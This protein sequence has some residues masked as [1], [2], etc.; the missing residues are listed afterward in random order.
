MDTAS[1][2]NSDSGLAGS[3]YEFISKED[4]AP[5]NQL[6][7]A[8]S[9]SQD[10]S[11][12]AFDESVSESV[13]SLDQSRQDDVHSIASTDHLDEDE[14][15]AYPH[16]YED[17]HDDAS[18]APDDDGSRL[19]DLTAVNQ[20][21]SGKPPLLT[22]EE[23]D[24]SEAESQSSIEY[25]RQSLGT[26]SI[27][28]PEGSKILSLPLLSSLD[29]IDQPTSLARAEDQM[30]WSTLSEIKSKC[31]DAFATYVPPLP[32]TED[33]KATARYR[34]E[35][36]LAWGLRH[37]I[38]TFLENPKQ[39]SLGLAVLILSNLLLMYQP[40]VNTYHPLAPP[41]AMPQS[42]TST[43]A[44]TTPTLEAK[45]AANT[46]TGIALVPLY[47]S[48]LQP[49]FFSAKKPSISF[50]S[51]GYSDL[52]AYFSPPDILR[53][54][55]A[56][57]EC[58]EVTAQ[59]DDHLHPV[60]FKLDFSRSQDSLRVLFDQPE[61]RGTLQVS[62][63]STC[64]PKF[65]T[66]VKVH[67]HKGIAENLSG[68]LSELAE[69]LLGEYTTAPSVHRC[70]AMVT[71]PREIDRRLTVAKDNGVKMVASGF[72]SATQ[73]MGPYGDRLQ[74]AALEADRRIDQATKMLKKVSD[75]T[76]PAFL[77]IRYQ[78]GRIAERSM[79][80]ASNALGLAAN[81]LASSAKLALQKASASQK[82]H[83][84]HLKKAVSDIDLRGVQKKL[85]FGLLDAQVGAKSWW[86]RATGRQDQSEEYRHRAREFIN[87]L[88]A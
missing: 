60:P 38:R 44:A 30:S 4:G 84:A 58:F 53:V 33:K 66:M 48:G 11:Q 64:R 8:Y 34:E 5:R 77:K 71:V 63:E 74:K 65:E 26:P 56:K 82:A 27:M 87:E 35:H 72:Q 76:E 42:S 43:I 36:R 20:E 67:F 14:E 32:P 46:K 70:P 52:T 39:I 68:C 83:Q 57:P 79:V 80:S 16:H 1:E 24:H 78:G 15:Y 25:T 22:E 7:S 69:Y 23:Q 75:Y 40:A 85:R 31:A 29:A 51:D 59:R 19:T 6:P 62:L 54:W 9:E 2:T 88:R 47:E 81:S 86:L 37:C 13:G 21:E 3:T 49:S 73:I 45:P 18:T 10:D 17:D 61:A 28:T 12:D 50:E 41:V 55:Q